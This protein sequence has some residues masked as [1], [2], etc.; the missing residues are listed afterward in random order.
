M[1][2]ADDYLIERLRRRL[3]GDEVAE[4]GVRVEERGGAVVLSGTV[5]DAMSRDAIMRIAGEVSG[6]SPVVC[7][8]RITSSAAPDHAEDLP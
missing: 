3:A 8:L 4:L 2:A 6:G 1:T 7:D 5:S